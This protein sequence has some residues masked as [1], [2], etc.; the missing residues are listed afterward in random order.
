[1]FMEGKAD[2]LANLDQNSSR[3]KETGVE[4][5]SVISEEK[6]VTRIYHL[7]RGVTD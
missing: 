3:P 1:M 5:A 7:R 2:N 6:N 4:M